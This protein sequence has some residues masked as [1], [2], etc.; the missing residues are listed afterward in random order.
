MATTN[1]TSVSLKLLID[2]KGR[3]VLFTEATKE[4]V[5]FL[6]TLLSL[7][8]GTVIR[9]LLKNGMVG[10]LG[11]LY[12]S[13]ENLSYTYLQPNINKDILLKPKSKVDGANIL[14][15]LTNND[16]NNKQLYICQSCNRC[17][18]NVSGRTCPK[19]TYY[20]MSTLVT[21]V[22]PQAPTTNAAKTSASEGGY[23]KGV[24]TYMIM[25]N[26]EVKPMSTISS[27][28]VL[29]SFNITEVGAL[30]EKVVNLGMEEV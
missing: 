1:T 16:S 30:E 5:D 20:S 14:H 22:A 26:L 23:V 10:C 2:T 12:E 27:I 21:Y 4:V 11:Q 8:V 18:S 17:I 9:L 28:A 29:N 19:C 24:V 13:V 6:F 25:D 15:L 7:P 3:K